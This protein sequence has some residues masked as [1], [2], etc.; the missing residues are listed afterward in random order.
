MKTYEES[1]YFHEGI[2]VRFRFRPRK[3][4]RRH[5][6]VAFA[7]VQKGRHEFYGFDGSLLDH[8]RAAV[9]WVM[10]SFDGENSYYLCKDLDLTIQRAVAALIDS[11][12]EELGISKDQ[13]TLLGS[14]KGA[15]AALHL[16]LTYGY[17]NIVGAVPQTVLGTYT[18]KKIP[19]TFAYMANED[20]DFS[21][22]QL[23]EYVPA[24]VA[25]PLS[26]DG[27]IY[28]VSSHADPEYKVHIEPLLQNFASYSNF[29][30]LMTDSKLVQSHPDVAEYNT[31]FILSVLYQLA[32]GL[33]PRFG[34]VENGG[35]ESEVDQESLN[36][37]SPQED[38]ETP[39]QVLAGLHWI[40]L[41]GDHIDFR[42]YATQK[43]QSPAEN[44]GSEPK[45]LFRSVAGGHEI[46]LEPFADKSLNAKLYDSR[47]VDY[48]W[49]GLKPKS[50]DGVEL[51][52]LPSGVF[53]ILLRPSQ[54]RLD[55]YWP[56]SASKA[57]EQI[58]TSGEWFYRLSA[59]A[60]RVEL[61]KVSLR[62]TLATDCHFELAEITLNG[63]DLSLSGVFAVPRES[64]RTWRSGHFA[65]LL[66]GENE[67]FSTMLTPTRTLWK[68]TSDF[69]GFSDSYGFSGFKVAEAGGT[70]V[71]DLEP[72]EYQVSVCFMKDD[73]S[74]SIPAGYSIKV[75]AKNVALSRLST[76][77][78]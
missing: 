8:L 61:A 35:A 30:L 40:K 55:G 28:L 16:G 68:P 66:S 45:L 41:T 14:S 56:A 21:E 70:S 2:E 50:E 33:S 78:N 54:S 64:M 3:Q 43:W 34:V 23:N 53:D 62:G 57:V 63:H 5:L 26:R 72:G 51:G 24:L 4:D 9:L 59:N 11:K 7:G 76:S 37:P 25:E 77:A 31:P 49:A 65:L 69:D 52:P 38:D 36:G 12:L 74:Y 22:K 19:E 27:N 18:R 73:R 75:D 47:F 20:L 39:P 17:K 58:S 29:N 48:L 71:K 32:E 60:N 6:V 13:C 1:S 42:G 67:C 10:D 44:S 46:S 15:T